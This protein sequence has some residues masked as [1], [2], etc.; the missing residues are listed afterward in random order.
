MWKQWGQYDS[1]ESW[2]IGARTV[3]EPRE[4]RQD[5][6]QPDPDAV[7]AR[8][9]VY[10]LSISSWADQFLLTGALLFDLWFDQPHRPTRDIDLLGFGPSE[11][12]DLVEVFQQVCVQTSDD[13]MVFDQDSVQAGRIRKDANY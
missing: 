13:G 12:D 9:A 3:T 11:I 10:R 7:F 4:C 8:V 6:L 1:S 2:R 5:R